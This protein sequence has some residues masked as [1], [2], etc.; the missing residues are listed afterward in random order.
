MTQGGILLQD[1][2]EEPSSESDE[3]LPAQLYTRDSAG[4]FVPVVV[5]ALTAEPVEGEEPDPPLVLAMQQKRH[6]GPLPSAETFR[7]YGDVL[8]S[9]PERIMQMAEKEQQ[10]THTAMVTHQ[11]DERHLVSQGQ[12][13]GFLSMMVALGGG[14]YVATLGHIIFAC[15]LVSPA[16]LTP[17]MRFY[18]KGKQDA[19]SSKTP[20]AAAG[21]SSGDAAAIEDE[22][23]S[24]HTP[25]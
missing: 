13:M 18:F 17:I 24:T 12:W 2:N 3:N 7:G 1:Q 22:A 14:I 10:A 4:N 15:A 23:G 8:P 6:V 11:R 5:E 20:D 9:A 19:V 21:S 16:V 25:L